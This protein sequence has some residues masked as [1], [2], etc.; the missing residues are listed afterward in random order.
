M[1]DSPPR[2]RSPI[3]LHCHSLESDGELSPTEVVERAKANGVEILSLTDH[4]TISG[5]SEAHEA[6]QRERISLI[7]GIEF[8]CE[9]QGRTIH[10]LGLNFDP[11]SS[12]IKD[13]QNQQLDARVRRAEVIAEK[14]Q[15][16][17]LPDV[18][19]DAIKLSKNGVPGRPHFAEALV[20]LGL[21]SDQAEAFKKY[22]GS[23]KAGDVKSMW[24]SL[25]AVLDWI[26]EAQGNSVIAHPR[27]YTMSLTKLRELIVDFKHANG[28]GLEVVV[29]GQK[30]GE[31]GLLSDLC[32]RFE[33]QGSVGSD[34]HSPRFPWADL[35]KIPGLPQSVTPIWSDWSNIS[36]G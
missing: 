24:P 1:P 6:A 13:A 20:S 25:E 26:H 32:Q 11:T 18:L 4:D 36:F 22:L 27:K 33:L 12:V 21:V 23:G 35:G 9:W 16:K 29:S 34:F 2:Y 10:I 15:K 7:S 3:D 8:S 30:Q 19:G 17:G 5:W 28:Q 14:L 31:V